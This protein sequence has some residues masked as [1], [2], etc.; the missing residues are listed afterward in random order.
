[1]ADIGKA[2]RAK[3]IATA[4]ITAVISERVYPRKLPQAATLPAA[5]YHVISGSDE[6][7][8]GGLTGL[9]HARIQIDAVASTRL[10][11]NS[12]AVTI[13]DAL[14]AQDV[15]PGTWGTVAVRACTSA[16]ADRYDSQ[17]L[18]DGSDDDQHITM[19]DY[20]ISYLG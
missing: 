17:P 8:L 20:L 1:M 3:M 13:R 15:T 18:G 2:L 16:A 14:A 7:D 9:V 5:V 10:V 6:T 4:A 12:L 19:R 11:A